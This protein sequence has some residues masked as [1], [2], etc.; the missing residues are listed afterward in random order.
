MGV[1]FLDE[2]RVL[3]LTDQRGML[4]GRML[5]DLGADVVQ[6]EPVGGSPARQTAPFL[7]Q[8]GDARTS[9]YWDAYAANKRGIIYDPGTPEGRAGLARLAAAADVV[10]ESA[11]PEAEQVLGLDQDAAMAANPRLVWCSIS[12][13]GSDGPKAGY[14]ASDL[15]VWAAGG[16]LAPNTERHSDRPPLRISVPQAFLHAAADAAAGILL[17]LT[18]RRATGAGQHVDVSAQA[19]LGITTM[20]VALTS[21]TDPR[22][23]TVPKG[24]DLSGSGS[25]SRRTKWEGKDGFIE[26]NLAMGPATGRFTNSFF[27]WMATE[28]VDVGPYSDWDWTSVHLRL[29]A[30]EVTDADIEQARSMVA[31]FLSSRTK[32]DVTEAAVAHKLLTVGI[33]DASDLGNSRQLEARGYWT[34]MGEGHR[35][36][37]LPG[38][39]A[40]ID[41]PAFA[42]RR[43][44]P[45][46]GE[47]TA[48]VTAE[49]LAPVRPSNL[50]PLTT[51]GAAPGAKTAPAPAPG[52]GA[53]A[54]P[55]GPARPPAP[56]LDGLKVLDLSWVVA[57]PV[58]GRALADFGATVLRVESSRRIE[59]ARLMPPFAHG[60][61]HPQGSA[62]Y[63]TCNA[64]KL[65]MCL[66]LT[67]ESG[68]LVVRD[69][70]RWADVVVESFS[71]GTMTRWGLSQETLRAD[72]PGLIV[73]STSLCGQT[74]PWSSLAGFGNV[75]AALAGFQYIAGWPDLLPLGP[76]GPYTDFVAPRFALVTLLAALDWRRSSG[77][78]CSIDVSQV[79]AGIQFLA[80]EMADWFATG[81]LAERCGNQDRQYAPH[82]VY[83]CRGTGRP[84]TW[85]AVA[86]RDDD[87]WVRLARAI[88][89]PEAATD[90]RYAH[91]DAR[92]AASD[93]L[94][95]MLGGWTAGHSGPE[96][97][98]ILQAVGVPAHV[99]ATSSDFCTDPQL[100]HRGHLVRLP[101]PLHGEVTVEAPRYRLSATPGAVTTH[102]PIF[103]EHTD[104]VLRDL[105]G[106]G[107]EQI[108]ALHEAGVLA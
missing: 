56:V 12:P 19:S 43:P 18:A 97:E 87:D 75:G 31:D 5:A 50:A 28:G 101:H 35:Q 55:R 104:Q 90:S 60:V 107:E 40:A 34:T 80:P 42:Y 67:T 33:F 95:R 86:A 71:P 30:G 38:P 51:P 62:L 64:G 84:G 2:Y 76:F 25:I 103:H 20:A 44:A 65:G 14:A 1:G 105:L 46:I 53:G 100:A 41:Q 48:E 78:G 83:P 13:F 23:P 57:G 89:R 27:R 108:A 54:S 4:A 22:P 10:I 70:A 98:A 85:V 59:T 93:E 49:W 77:Q 24:P 15:V 102:A 74:G 9:F 68:R 7:E 73:L 88:G 66:D 79:E 8:A 91:A 92:L 3:D 17:A 6:A 26:F 52:P 37:T 45:L 96:V 39:F 63:E 21:V 36:R 32:L 11:G 72:N 29:A 99:V 16:P 69:L 94:D 81:H 47:H 106:Y 58:I 82:G 61:R